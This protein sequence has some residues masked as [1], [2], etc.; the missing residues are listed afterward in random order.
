MVEKT[1]GIKFGRRNLYESVVGGFVFF[2]FLDP[3]R[4]ITINSSM[5]K[6]IKAAA[7]KPDLA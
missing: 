4:L 7:A 2:R 3:R 5:S 1:Y 6:F